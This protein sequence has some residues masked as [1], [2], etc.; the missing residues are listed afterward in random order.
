MHRRRSGLLPDGGDHLLAERSEVSGPNQAIRGNWPGRCIRTRPV[1]CPV[2]PVR[3]SRVEPGVPTPD[4]III[5]SLLGQR[6]FGK[7]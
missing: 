1:P 3:P 2:A 7:C 4:S 5:G 6:S